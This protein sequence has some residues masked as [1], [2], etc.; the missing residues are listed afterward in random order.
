MS[1]SSDPT[2]FTV[3]KALTIMRHIHLDFM[4]GLLQ[5]QKQ[6]NEQYRAL[7]RRLEEIGID[8]PPA[9]VERMAQILKD[10]RDANLSENASN[11][12]DGSGDVSDS[13]NDASRST[14]SKDS[15]LT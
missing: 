3:E 13:S 5:L 4:I 9:P 7:S 6:S 11:N 8:K 12:T 10:H 1:G 14:E 2:E 15:D